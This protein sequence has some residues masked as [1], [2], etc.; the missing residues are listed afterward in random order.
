MRLACASSSSSER[1]PELASA[2]VNAQ[3]KRGVAWWLA[4][5]R[6]LLIGLVAL[7][8]VMIVAARIL[9]LH[10]VLVWAKAGRQGLAASRSDLE[11]IVAI[12]AA[13][14]IVVWVVAGLFLSLVPLRHLLVPNAA[15]WKSSGHGGE[16]R[17]RYATYLSRA[18]GFT[19]WFI[20]AEIVV[21][22]VSQHN[23]LLETPWL[24]VAVSLL[25]V[26]ILLVFAVWVFADGF[27]PP[28][29]ATA[30]RARGSGGR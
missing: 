18:I 12:V 8:V 20:A 2:R 1:R 19:Y 27:R 3:S 26:V 24:P 28:Q 23:G 9:P 5:V 29:R 11:I 17:R 4:P 21:A 22:M 14:V 13:G 30:Q 25:F 16:M 10:I 6:P 15:Y 7:A